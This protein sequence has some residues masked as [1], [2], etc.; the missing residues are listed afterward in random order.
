MSKIFSTWDWAASP[1]LGIEAKFG[2]IEAKFLDFSDLAARAA[3]GLRA[4]L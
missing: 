3:N 4:A 1:F 2:K